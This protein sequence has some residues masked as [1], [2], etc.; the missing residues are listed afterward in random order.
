MPRALQAALP[1]SDTAATVASAQIFAGTS[2][3]A[4]PTWKPVFYP[5]GLPQRRFLEYY[6][7]QL[8]S[9]EVNYTFRALPTQTMLDNWL[10]A[11]T[12]FFRFSF[13]A[14]QR[15]TH[16]KRLA[17]CEADVAFF[18]SVLNSVHQAGRLGLLL[19]QL[20]PNMKAEPARLATFLSAPA[21]RSDDAP[22]IAFE[23]RNESW[24]REETY[25]ILREHNAALCVAESDDLRTPEVHTA[26]THTS[27]R[28]RRSE[29]YT[30]EELAAFA[31]RF[32]A[33][34]ATRETYLYFKHED[35]PTGALNA[36]ALL[37]EI[38]K[39]LHN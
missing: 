29:A 30:P 19:F 18:C 34:A 28:L 7:T 9:V 27:F 24:F 25:A 6:A 36:T 5:D 17:N 38:N 31:K 22:R 39:A 21:L 4:Y 1:P 14:P 11:T 35:E 10:A 15:I 2:G 26:T 13:K 3:W 16:I 12:H 33:L 23:F 37:S 8:S 20:P 32:L